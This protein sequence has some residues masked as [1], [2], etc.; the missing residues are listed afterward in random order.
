M[1]LKGNAVLVSSDLAERLK[2]EMRRKSINANELAKRAHVGHS[3][4]YDI[5]NGKS[6]NPTTKKLSAVAEILQTSVPYLLYGKTVYKDVFSLTPIASSSNIDELVAIPSITIEKF[7][8]DSVVIM[9]ECDTKPYYFHRQWLQ[10]LET[11]AESL[12]VMI[13]QDDRMSPTLNNKDMII[14]DISHKKPTPSGLFAI[15]DGVGLAIKRLE[16]IYKPKKPRINVISDN[17]AYKS[18]ELSPNDITIIGKAVW[19]SRHL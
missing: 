10:K 14:I 12:R 15:Y 6:T 16:Y 8:N 9:E 4:V 3:F 11:K 17:P 19:I 1:R 13:M 5:L 2:S 7:A 18:Y